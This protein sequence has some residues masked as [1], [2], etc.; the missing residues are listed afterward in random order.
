MKYYFILNPNSQTGKGRL[1]W[2]KQLLPCLKASK[3]HWKAFYTRYPGHC[4]QIVSQLTSTGSEPVTIVI[5]G[6]DGTL[7]EAVNGIKHF[8]NVTLGYIPTGSSND[9]ARGMKQNSD[10]LE[11]LHNILQ[12]KHELWLDYGVVQAPGKAPQRFIVSSG[13]GFDAYVTDEA[14]T[15]PIK[16][17]LN[18]I[19]MGKLTY[20]LIA[21]KKLVTISLQ[22][23]V[24]AKHFRMCQI[25]PGRTRSRRRRQNHF[26]SIFIQLIHHHIQ[27]FK[28]IHPLRRFQ[29]FPRE[30]GQGYTVHSGQLHQAHIFL[31]NLRMIQPLIRIIVRPMYHMRK[32]RN[33][34]FAF[35]HHQIV[36]LP[37]KFLDNVQIYV[38]I[39]Y[40][41]LLQ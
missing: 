24:D 28:G 9:F 7:N 34:R 23:V 33:G 27:P 5:L 40:F 41:W 20:A 2:K 18:A 37:N 15:S 39:S 8:E 11:T 25:H 31:N 38:S 26:H 6:G 3:S 10:P 29:R 32:I 30:N 14:L 36:Y 21:L 1:I 35:L 22:P 17:V 19:H 12:N 16:N 4:T 13:I